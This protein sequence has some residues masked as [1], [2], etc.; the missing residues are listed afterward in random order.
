MYHLNCGKHVHWFLAQLLK[1]SSYPNLMLSSVF[2]IDLVKYSCNSK[3]Q[4]GSLWYIFYD[5]QRKFWPIYLTWNGTDFNDVVKTVFKKCSQRN[6]LNAVVKGEN[7]LVLLRFIT[8]Q[9]RFYVNIDDDLY[10]APCI[11][12][13]GIHFMPRRSYQ[14]IKSHINF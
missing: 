9:I 3:V 7:V 5:K 13:K 12:S 6:L 8:D 11:I 10:T 14:E 4:D 1:K 2:V